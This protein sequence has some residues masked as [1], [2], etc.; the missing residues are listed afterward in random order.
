[1][2]VNALRLGTFRIA[3]PRRPGEGLRVGTVRFLPRGVAKR[4]YARRDYFD[5]WFPTVAPSRTLVG[6]LKSRPW[7]PAVQ[8]RYAARYR[9]EMRAPD[10]ARAL[11]LLAAVA[12]RTPISVGCYCEDERRCHRSILLELIRAAARKPS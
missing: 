3:T 6:W 10:A 8:H 7:S 1:V 2:P 9:R 4:D 5:V 11:E 12:Q